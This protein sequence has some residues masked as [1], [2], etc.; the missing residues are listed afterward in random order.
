[1]RLVVSREDDRTIR[2][3]VLDRDRFNKHCQKR[4]LQQHQLFT[5]LMDVLDKKVSIASLLESEDAA[6]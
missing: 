2:V 1:M 5:L 4:G 6:A 3:H